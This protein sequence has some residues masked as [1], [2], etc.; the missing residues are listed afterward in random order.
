[1][2]I[3]EGVGGARSP[4]N[5]KKTLQM[6]AQGTKSRLIQIKIDSLPQPKTAIAAKP[7]PQPPRSR[8]KNPKLDS[9]C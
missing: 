6:R 2:R 8:Y 4:A 9:Q 1:M 3:F 5:P 7:L